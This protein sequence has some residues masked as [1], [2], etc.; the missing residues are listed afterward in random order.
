MTNREPTV[1]PEAPEA[2]EAIK[3]LR[4][5]AHH[6]SREGK[7]IRG[8]PVAFTLAV[9]A[10]VILTYL[11]AEWHHSDTVALKDATIENQ[12]TRI[13]ILEGELKSAS[14]QLAA[15]QARRAAIRE[16]LLEIYIAAGPMVGKD[17]AYDAN[18]N[19]RNLLALD[20]LDS[21]IRT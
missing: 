17:V 14:P 6:F 3:W 4:W 7:V 8:A 16:R 20:Q 9:S 21:E 5:L 1:P 12:R 19:S 18:D 11:A 15:I 10:L 13:A 2:P